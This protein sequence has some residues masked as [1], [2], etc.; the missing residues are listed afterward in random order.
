[1]RCDKKTAGHRRAGMLCPRASTPKEQGVESLSIGPYRHLDGAPEGSIYEEINL[2]SEDGL[3]LT[4]RPVR[5]YHQWT[6]SH[7]RVCIGAFG[8]CLYRT[9]GQA[10]YYDDRLVEGLTLPLPADTQRQFANF[11]SYIVIM[12]DRYYYQPSTGA[13]GPIGATVEF[14][15]H[16]SLESAAVVV[17]E[18]SY[19]EVSDLTDYFQVGDRVRLQVNYLPPQSTIPEWRDV[20]VTLIVVSPHYIRVSDEEFPA[21]CDSAVATARISREIPPLEGMCVC[22]ER[23]FGYVGNTVY[24]CRQGDVRNWYPKTDSDEEGYEKNTAHHKPFTACTVYRGK[25]VFF[26][27]E[28]IS[29]VYG[30]RPCAFSVADQPIWGVMAGAH[31]SLM[32]VG[33]RLYYVSRHGVTVYDGDEAEI[34]SDMLGERM[35]SGVAGSDGRRYYLS[36]TVERD[37]EPRRMNFVYSLKTDLWHC[38]DGLAFADFV[39]RHGILYGLQLNRADG[40][41]R[42]W[43]MSGEPQATDGDERSELDESGVLGLGRFGY[44]AL[45]VKEPCSVMELAELAGDNPE[46]GYLKRLMLRLAVGES[47][48]VRVYLSCDGE[49][50]RLMTEVTATGPKWV[51]IPISPNRAVS[52]R[53]RLEATNQF[54]LYGIGRMYERR[55][56]V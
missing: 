4:S 56:L 39:C 27:E 16:L 2:S 9:E 14:N 19:D 5:F 10:F 43:R 18:S 37:G 28:G 45:G 30:D 22:H 32:T 13:Y 49:P 55:G 48:S 52:Y 34:L 26:S 7:S 29:T 17:E 46:R 8:D 33:G 23:L 44:A 12:P 11:G 25:P 1:M 54:K 35:L 20:Y 53:V 24:A 36:A 31:R 50:Y 41:A 15:A 21:N 38:E 47:S 40:T 3:V 42:L 6:P 51:A